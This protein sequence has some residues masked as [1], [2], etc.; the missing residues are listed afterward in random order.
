MKWKIVVKL[1]KCWKLFFRDGLWN[2]T[3]P[4]PHPLFFFIN[5]TCARR[6]AVNLVSGQRAPSAYFP[7]AREDLKISPAQVVV[8]ANTLTNGKTPRKAKLFVLVLR[9]LCQ[10]IAYGSAICGLESPQR[11]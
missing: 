3:I 11:A 5:T 10:L 2:F 6:P 9:L 4:P 1:C 7:G 8:T